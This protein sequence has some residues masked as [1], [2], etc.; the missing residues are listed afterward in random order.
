[1]SSREAVLGQPSGQEDGDLVVFERVEAHP[2]GAFMRDG[3]GMIAQP[4]VEDVFG[5]GGLRKVHAV[6]FR[7]QEAEEEGDGGR[8]HLPGP[9][10]DKDVVEAMCEGTLFEGRGVS[11]VEPDGIVSA[12]VDG[13][14]QPDDAIGMREGVEGDGI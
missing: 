11:V 2:Q 9:T 14:G 12:F 3:V 7:F 10:M 6:A 13:V 5:M 8:A 4:C 1:M